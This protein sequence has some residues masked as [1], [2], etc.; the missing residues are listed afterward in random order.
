MG[1]QHLSTASLPTA[2]TAATTAWTAAAAAVDGAA[3]LTPSWSRPGA[4]ALMAARAV[5][6]PA[7]TATIPMAAPAAVAVSGRMSL[8][9]RLT[10]PGATPWTTTTLQTTTGV[11]DRSR[12][13]PSAF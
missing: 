9:N 3:K 7:A 4:L 12:V 10:P 13:T 6:A 11:G 1:P 8:N 2:A 5:V